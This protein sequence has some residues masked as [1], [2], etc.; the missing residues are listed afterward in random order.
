M[1]NVA[2]YLDYHGVL[3]ECVEADL[4]RFG[5]E[6]DH[7]DVRMHLLSFGGMTRARQ[8]LMALTLAGIEDLFATLTFTKYR[9][10]T[11]RQ[12]D[13]TQPRQFIPAVVRHLFTSSGSDS[14]SGRAAAVQFEMFN[15]GKDDYFLFTTATWVY[16]RVTVFVDDKWDNLRAAARVVQNLVCVEMRRRRWQSPSEDCIHVRTLAHVHVELLHL[17]DQSR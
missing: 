10:S 14:S 12:L 11:E 13:L 17:Q 8:T 15:G 3:D 9:T 6:L 16:D 4:A 2:V 1:A 7:M 5:I